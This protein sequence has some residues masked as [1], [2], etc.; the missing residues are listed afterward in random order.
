[1]H[2]MIAAWTPPFERSKIAAIIYAG[3]ALGTVIS[4]PM[5][6]LIAGWM[7][8][9]AVFYIMGGLSLVWCVL[10]PMLVFDSPRKHPFI[11]QVRIFFKSGF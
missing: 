3:T 10:W 9:P 1:M 6:G 7:G 8:W 4:M 11:T 2:V 5:S